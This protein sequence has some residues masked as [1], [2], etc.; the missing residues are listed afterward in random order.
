MENLSGAQVMAT[1]FEGECFP[2]SG[3]I[4][5]RGLTEVSRVYH[6]DRGYEGLDKKL[7]KLGANI[8]RVKERGMKLLRTGE[9]GFEKY[10]S[11]IEKR[12]G[13]DSSR[14]EGTVR[15]ILKDVRE[16]GDRALVH[17]TQ[18]FDQVRVAIRDL[19]V[20]KGRDRR[21]PIRKVPRGIYKDTGEGGSPYPKRFTGSR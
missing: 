12:E 17:Y 15:S 3:R 20:K 6:L 19:Q 4:G 11:E 14:L 5:R 13:Q 9:K 18:V 2:D 10:L 7:A 8:K 1:R 21:R 16:R